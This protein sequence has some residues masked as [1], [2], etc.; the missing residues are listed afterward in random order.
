MPRPSRGTSRLCERQLRMIIAS[1]T[2]RGLQ[3]SPG[4]KFFSHIK[5]AEAT[6][7]SRS[8]DTVA[9]LHAVN[10]QITLPAL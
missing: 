1:V 7:L 8:D 6:L 4:N 5:N 10:L 2:I 9:F 3:K